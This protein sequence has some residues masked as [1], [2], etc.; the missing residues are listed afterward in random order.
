MLAKRMKNTT[1]CRVSLELPFFL[2]CN[3]RVVDRSPPAALF[4]RTQFEEM[5]IKVFLPSSVDSFLEQKTS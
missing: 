4:Y 2:S 5:T 3:Q 1:M